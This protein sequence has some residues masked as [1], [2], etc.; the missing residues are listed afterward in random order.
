MDW[1]PVCNKC[2]DWSKPIKMAYMTVFLENYDKLLL[3]YIGE[4]IM[5]QEHIE[6][7]KSTFSAYV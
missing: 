1:L 4:S 3:A 6:F 5:I 7:N 2:M